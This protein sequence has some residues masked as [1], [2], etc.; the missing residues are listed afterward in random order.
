[1]LGAKAQPIVYPSPHCPLACSTQSRAW[2]P[3]FSFQR[4]SVAMVSNGCLGNRDSRIDEVDQCAAVQFLP[5]KTAIRC[6]WRACWPHGCLSG[7]GDFGVLASS[8]HSSWALSTRTVYFR[9]L[10]FFF[11]CI[12]RPYVAC[13]NRI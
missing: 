9:K 2:L 12:Y 3:S 6:D 5:Q 4:Y 13:S 8:S 10:I 1:M 7:T 11:L